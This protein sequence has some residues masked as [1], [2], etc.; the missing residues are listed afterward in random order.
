MRTNAG[1]ELEAQEV[2]S[3]HELL[4][5]LRYLDTTLARAVDRAQAAFNA[6]GAVDRFRG[7]YISD[8]HV[9]RMLRQSPGESIFSAPTDSVID[10]LAP[11]ARLTWLAEVFA[12]DSFDTSVVLLA[13]APEIDLRYERL[14]AYLQDD[15]TRRKPTVDLALSLFCDLPHERALARSHFTFDAPLLRRRVISLSS[16]S[17]SGGSSLLSHSI[18]LDEQIVN[19]LLGH[20]A[21]DRRLD[22]CCRLSPTVATSES[23]CGL[24][25]RVLVAL[26]EQ[27]A[28]ARE[29]LD[30]LRVHLHGPEGS[31]RRSAARAIA[32]AAQAP[33]L[34]LDVTRLLDAPAAAELAA[35]AVR[36]AWLRG[37]VLTFEP[38]LP[39]EREGGDTV[40]DALERAL[41]EHP[42]TSIAIASAPPAA[43]RH[44]SAQHVLEL[45]HPTPQFRRE[46][47][48]RALQAGG[49]RLDDASIDA[50]ASQF[51]LTRRQIEHACA[52]A[53]TRAW[54]R[55]A[56]DRTD[57]IGLARPTREDW[58]AGARAQGGE[59]LAELATRIR[60]YASWSDI[61]LPA[62]SMTQL[63]ELCQRVALRNVVMGEWGFDHR[64]SRGRGINALFSG[65]SGTGKT[66]AAE[67]VA[68]ELKLDLF[69]I[70]LAGIVSKYIGETEKNLD[71]IFACAERANGIL[72]FDEADALFG[73]RSEVRDSHDRY[74]NLEISYLLQKMEQFDGIAILA[75]NL[76]GNLDE[77]FMRRLSFTVHFPVPDEE[78]RQRIW[79]TIW[80]SEAPLASA[81]DF[82]FLARQFALSGGNIKNIALGAAF[83]AAE[84]GEPIGMRDLMRASVREYQK[85][86]KTLT[87]EEMGP[88]ADLV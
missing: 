6:G 32:A 87:K 33:L 76:R 16:D 52:A 74:A 58:L 3:F 14:Y 18:Q 49:D 7:L 26:G 24:P 36:E 83:F 12:L 43:T 11:D 81:L 38:W 23:A 44:G 15:V 27:V 75:T 13:L 1:T 80:P 40:R 5:A 66:M 65:P 68:S 57:G 51:R 69:R 17:S 71:R 55:A 34:S 42:I 60:A 88:Y 21:L 19:L 85:L 70:E 39:L 59:E 31:G 82:E 8:E 63:R 2:D 41:A 61:V 30:A 78:S 67:I 50:L 28:R 9:E 29:S 20:D 56:V 62:D 86:G 77:A 72:L 4:P 37:A 48:R 73:K 64:L 35:V 10:T 53:R 22:G 54:R 25:P 79:S 45:V 46:H 84:R 47:W